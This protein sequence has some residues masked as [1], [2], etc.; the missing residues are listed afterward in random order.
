MRVPCIA[1][2]PG[3]VPAKQVSSEVGS[4]VDFFPTIAKL[5]GASLPSDR[6]IDGIDLMP[7]LEGNPLPERTIYYYRGEFLRAIRLG[8]WKLHLSYFV[9]PEGGKALETGWVTP[10]TP[11]LFDLNQ[12]PSERF[13]LASQHPEV[14][15]QLKETA[16]HYQEEIRR[17]GENKELIDWFVNRWPTA[18]RTGE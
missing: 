1:R 8:K 3:R 16:S 5:A 12:D 7:A 2:W 18:P 4:F 15:A 14:V 10:E 6:P 11:L 9:P 17:K 13:N